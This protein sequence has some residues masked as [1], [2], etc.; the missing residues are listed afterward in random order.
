MCG[1]GEGRVWQIVPLHRCGDKSSL[2]M[3]NKMCKSIYFP[4]GW[5]L[6]T[7]SRWSLLLLHSSRHFVAPAD[8]LSAWLLFRASFSL[9]L[10]LGVLEQWEL[11]LASLENQQPHWK[12]Q[13]SLVV[14]QS[15]GPSACL[16]LPWVKNWHYWQSGLAMK[17][18]RRNLAFALQAHCSIVSSGYVLSIQLMQSIKISTPEKLK[19]VRNHLQVHL[20]EAGSCVPVWIQVKT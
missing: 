17:F 4:Q 18:W 12:Q 13:W 11:I 9:P 7:T 1:E 15:F 8:L 20:V 6:G 3:S 5:L 2:K 10:L 14:L 19:W 16:F